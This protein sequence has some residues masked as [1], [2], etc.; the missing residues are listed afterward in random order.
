MLMGILRDT[1]FPPKSN[2]Y[3]AGKQPYKPYYK[4]G[5]RKRTYYNSPYLDE[6]IYLRRKLRQMEYQYQSEIERLERENERLKR[7]ERQLLIK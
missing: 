4:K 3:Q 2:Y 6:A 7:R 5:Q 1:F